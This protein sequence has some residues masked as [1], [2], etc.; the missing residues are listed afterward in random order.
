MA[1]A[2]PVVI[3]FAEAGAAARTSAR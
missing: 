2:C 3:G 1:S